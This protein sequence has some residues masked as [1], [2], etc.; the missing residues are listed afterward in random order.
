MKIR[1]VSLSH[2][3]DRSRLIIYSKPLPESTIA[4]AHRLPEKK[5]KG[6]DAYCPLGSGFCVCLLPMKEIGIEYR[7]RKKKKSLLPMKEI[8]I[9]AN[10]L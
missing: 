9:L 7:L 1:L 4:V 8:G 5:E 3:L 10:Y 2:R 6:T